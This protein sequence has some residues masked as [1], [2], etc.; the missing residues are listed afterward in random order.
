MVWQCS[1]DDGDD[2]DDADEDYSQPLSDSSKSEEEHVSL[3][4]FILAKQIF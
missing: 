1:D 2:E 4:H 3:L